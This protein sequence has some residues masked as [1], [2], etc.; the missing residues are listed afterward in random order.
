M[1]NYTPQ[2]QLKLE[3]FKNPFVENLDNNNRWIRLAAV[4]PWDELASV[5]CRKLNS[6][7]GRKSVDVRT[8]I[9]SLIVKHKL[10]LDD[11]GVIEMIQENVYL[12]YFC[13]LQEFTT[14]RVFDPS[15]FVEIRKRLGIKEFDKFNEL[16]ISKSEEIKPHQSR[17][18]NKPK[19]TDDNVD[20]PPAPN[21]GTLKVDA[22]ACDQEITYPNDVKLL[23]TAREKLELIIDKLYIKE[24][25]ITK[26]RNYRRNARRDYLNFAKKKKKS[27]KEIRKGVKNQLQYVRRDLDII[28]RLLKKKGREVILDT[29]DHKVMCT[30]RQVYKQQKEMYDKKSN[31][32]QDRIVSIHQPHVRPIV[33]GKNKSKTEFGSKI[34]VSEVGGFCRIDRLSW[35][36]FNESKDVKQQVK[37][38]RRLYGRYPKYFLGDQIYLTRENRKYLK[39]KGIIIFGKPLGRPP[40]HKSVSPSQRYRKKKKLAERNHIEAK[41]GQGKRGYGLN[42]IK[43]RLAN[44]S[45]SWVSSIFFVMNLL[46]LMEIAE[47]HAGFLCDFLKLHIIRIISRLNFNIH[48]HRFRFA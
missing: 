8:V 16:V 28:D 48:S 6:D 9:A 43:A 33:R 18:M 22:T 14:G 31:R 19:K 46:K 32:C 4:V 41:F 17:I 24:I 38:Y 37:N 10:Q 27:K 39:S 35:D 20:N 23:N 34:N 45:E 11:R 12:Q 7:M 25:D 29:A 1:I 2:S 3:F 13:G 44:T 21:K 47:K 30:I 36:T 42:N 26:P 40:K 15:L 5:Y